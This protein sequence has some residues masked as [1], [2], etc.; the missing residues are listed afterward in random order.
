MAIHLCAEEAAGPITERQ[1]DL[2]FAARGDC[3]R[4]QGIVDDL[5]DLSRI[6]SG[7]I[8][9]ARRPVAVRRLLEEA[10]DAVR[11]AAAEGQLGL[12]IEAPGPEEEALVDPERLALVLVNLLSNAV[13][14][15][16]PGGQVT[17]RAVR[18]GEGY[19]LEVADT[20]VG[21]APE[22]HE[23]IFEK[24]F[25]V[26]GQARGG[27]VGLGLFLAREIVRAH[28]GELAVESTP[29]AGSRFWFT[30][31]AA[32]AAPQAEPAGQA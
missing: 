24:Y 11:G 2:L 32:A 12:A 5:L 6:Q 27:S 20:G 31:P 7:R 16:P 22:Y 29:G 28:G 21:I 30:V 9:L 10:A 25:R 13:R 15:T 17:V 26:P 8:E 4:L 23:R 1:A 18:T 19:R 14:H 3:E